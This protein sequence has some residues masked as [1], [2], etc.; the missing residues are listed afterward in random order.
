MNAEFVMLLAIAFATALAI[1]A[2]VDPHWRA[3]TPRKDAS[4]FLFNFLLPLTPSV[5]PFLA[6]V[7][8]ASSLQR[9][10]RA[11]SLDLAR[12]TPQ[13]PL[14]IAAGRYFGAALPFWIGALVIVALAS[15]A[16]RTALVAGWLP[17]AAVAL[18]ALAL[19]EMGTSNAVPSW[20]ST[21]VMAAVI[22]PIAQHVAA[23]APADDVGAYI[24][25]HLPATMGRLAIR[26]SAFDE[27]SLLPFLAAAVFVAI[28]A[29]RVKRPLGPSL[30]GPAAAFGVIVA[31]LAITLCPPMVF[32][33]VLAGLFAVGASLVA[34]ER[35]SPTAP[36]PRLAWAGAAAAAAGLVLARSPALGD[37]AALSTGV[38][39]ALALATGLLIHEM[40]H[41][42]PS[43]SF[44]LRL[45][46]FL[47]L[48]PVVRTMIAGRGLGD[49]RAAASAPQPLELA[50]LA[51][52]FA[53]SLLLH[54]RRRAR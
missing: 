37:A 23:A 27:M 21:A 31:A 30:A 4:D 5:M 41:E 28:A 54:A 53:V 20:G 39:A 52:A 42:R 51:A 50:A 14:Q 29:G 40:A 45:A 34:E 43:L 46:I 8:I 17:A 24:R 13:T 25:A 9:D 26:P 22:L 1:G 49:E 44:G 38:A 10:R 6:M 33:R 12:I 11:G 36:W 18:P 16:P 15:V 48:E 2:R 19:L 32:P 7:I 35:E 3:P 47:G